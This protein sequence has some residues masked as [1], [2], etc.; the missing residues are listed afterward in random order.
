[1][2][3]KA[4]VVKDNRIYQ[5]FYFKNR[6][7]PNQVARHIV[8]VL[9]G[10]IDYFIIFVVND[11]GEVWRYSVMKGKDLKLYIRQMD[12]GKEF[13]SKNDLDMIFTGNKAISGGFV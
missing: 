9:K 12:K 3:Y 11:F 6:S 2:K 13:Y 7:H 4:E 5:E 8:Q 10:K 1:M